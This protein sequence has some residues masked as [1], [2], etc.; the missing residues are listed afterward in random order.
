MKKKLWLVSTTVLAG[1]ALGI[2]SVSADTNVS[3][4][5]SNMNGTTV[6]T[7]N[8]VNTDSSA[9]STQVSNSDAAV[10]SAS[11]DTNV[12][13]S[14]VANDQQTAT[15][16]QPATATTSQARADWYSGYSTG[17]QS[18]RNYDGTY[19]WTYRKADGT[20]ASNEWLLIN[21]SWYYFDGNTMA[22][23][24]WC[25]APW[26]GQGHSYYFD[27]NGHY[28]TNSWHS[29][30]NGK[31]AYPRYDWS[32]SKADGTQA[33]NEWLW[34]NGAWYYFD[35]NTMAAN[36]WHYAPWYGQYHSYY[37]DANG[38]YVTNSWHS[39]SNG[40]NQY[41]TWTYS[42]ADGTQANDQWLWINGAWY[43]FDGN[44]MAANGWH[45]APWNG[46]YHSYYFDA[47][48]HYVTNSWHS[49]SNG[50]NQYPT[51]TYS[52]ADGTQANNEWVWINGAWYY[53]DGNDMV[54][55]GWHYAPWNGEYREYYFD[56]NGHCL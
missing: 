26:Y 31:N 20:Q 41:P 49:T 46:Q 52:K 38:H 23:R 36:G 42:K 37:F 48:G 27:A 53:F 45:Y 29:Y 17:W 8:N 24:G 39:T 18:S 47:N 2:T 54:A 16:A 14:N 28:A 34:I 19:D 10:T 7:T 11:A 40:K 32:Y 12:Q 1:L 4:N 35:G 50:N 51:W 15:N 43:Y 22:N 21:G 6:A 55:N 33:N 3:T 9:V 25:Y 13:G 30:D 44:D 5:S 56:V